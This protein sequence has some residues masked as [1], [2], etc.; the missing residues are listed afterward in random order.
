MLG[1]WRRLGSALSGALVV[2]GAV[3]LGV[4]NPLV[5]RPGSSADV[6]PV[7]PSVVTYAADSFSRSV[8]GGWGTAQLGG[9]YE[10][11]GGTAA[12]YWVDGTTGFI[13]TTAGGSSR[14]ASLPDVSA[15]DIDLSFTVSPMSLAA[16]GSQYVYGVV[17]RARGS[18]EYRGQVRFTT[19]GGVGLRATVAVDG[20]ERALGVETI[21]TGLAYGPGTGIRVRMQAYGTYPTTI[22]LKAWREGDPE[23]GPW[24]YSVTDTEALLQEAGMIGIRV[25][26]SSSSMVSP[27]TFGFADLVVTSIGPPPN[28]VW[29]PYL[30]QLRA[31]GVVI[32]WATWSG[33]TPEVRYGAGPALGLSAGGASRTLDALGI[34]FNRVALSGLQ[35]ETTYYYKVFNDGIDQSPDSTFSFRTGVPAGSPDAFTLLAFGDFGANTGTQRRLRNRML[36]ETFDFI[37]TTGDNAYDFGSYQNFGANVFS[38][39]GQIF[40]RAGVWPSPGNHDYLTASAS[41]Y[42]DLFDLPD[43]SFRPGDYERYYSFD[44]G[45]AHFVV[46][47]SNNPLNVNDSDFTDDMFDW[48]RSDLARTTQPWKLIVFHHP[49]YS[50]GAHGSDP[51]VQSKLVPIFEAFKVDLVL[52]GHDHI[53]LRTFPLRGGQVTTAEQ[54]GIVYVVTGAGS[55]ADYGCGSAAWI[56][57]SYC[58]LGRGVY[59]RITVGGNRLRL[60]AVDENGTI[61]DSLA[62]SKP[63]LTPTATPTPT[64][65]PTPSPTPT[66]VSQV[67]SA[68]SGLTATRAGSVRNQRINL[69]WVDNSGNEANFVVERSTD[70]V[71]WTILAILAANTT[72]YSDRDIQPATTYYYRVRATNA[73]GSSAYSNVASATTR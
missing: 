33:G 51:R 27:V 15:Q 35:P 44:Y 26:V 54:G 64:S 47:D 72:T 41:P 52:T 39:Y 38:I 59:N 42:L 69:G 53:Y 16:G 31:T 23:P 63:A 13:S 40:P 9:N 11:S 32:L 10:V 22:Q 36:G 34:R 49:A 43:Q 7:A 37:I 5:S 46:V 8:T 14:L 60:E 73:A 1:V 12:D 21:I 20:A 70:A 24:A 55:A 6:G 48:L 57:V 3:G 30:Q 71:S 4:L 66:P 61:V 18:T 56:A 25:Y 19:S 17:R 28:L 58:S 67:P 45:W 68:A 29:K 2:A 50:T 65:S 62:C